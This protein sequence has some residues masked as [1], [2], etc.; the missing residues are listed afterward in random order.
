MMELKGLSIIGSKRG[1]TEN[2]AFQA[3]NPAT[4][5]AL[6]P[7]CHQ[8]TEEEVDRACSLAR[9]TFRTYRRK[10]PGERAA[11]LRKI[12]DEIEAL[13]DS[14]IERFV[15]E[16]GLPAGRAE[17]ERARTCGQLRL[18]A[19]T[20]ETPGWNRPGIEHARPD[21]KPLPKPD[22]R[23][24]SIG[25]GPVA[26]FGPAN[27]PLAFTVAGGDTASALAAGCPVVVKAH[28]S[29]PGVSELVGMAIRRAVEATEMPDG[30]FSLL[31][32]EGRA[33]GVPLVNH[34]AIKA[35]GFTGSEHVGRS[36]FN[37]A[38]SR[39]E[40]IPVFA[41]M[42]SIN[43]VILFPDALAENAKTIAE[44]LYGS[45]TLG[46]GQFC[47]N[48]GLVLIPEGAAGEFTEALL[49]KLESHPA[50]PML[51]RGTRRSY[52]EGLSRLGECH[53]VETLLAPRDE[54]GSGGCDAGPAL[55]R[56]NSE[57]FLVQPALF[58]EVFGPTTLLVTYRGI[59]EIPRILET[60]GG[61]LT[62]TFH[63]N[64]KDLETHA[65][66]IADMELMAG[67]IVCNG[68]PTGVEVC[69]TMI[70]GGPY[71]ATTDGRFTSVGTRAIERFLRPVCYQ[72]FPHT[73]LPDEIRDPE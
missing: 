19:E 72:G 36:L 15:A 54:S 17:G 2:T 13:G 40:P 31:F 27:F 32:G 37:L 53:E 12:A 11:F 46:V 25:I 33:V 55:Y 61:Q 41:E 57:A 43:P 7:A 39:P 70:H 16:S 62:L 66:V 28:S 44:G 24:R 48:P 18:F 50:Q 35:V 34:P 4:G 6:E 73:I 69:S 52:G 3:R 23:I 9:E 58:E 51:N 60:I 20:L 56:I 5:E 30:V 59:R 38:A 10:T 45:L 47:T 26:V 63:G 8:A 71:P 1:S 22:T 68:F 29:H 14:L 67:R 65:D 42:S 21:R 64:E 49:D